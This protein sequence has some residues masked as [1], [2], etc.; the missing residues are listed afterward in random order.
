MM[1][2]MG[3]ATSVLDTV[4]GKAAEFPRSHASRVGVRVG[5][6]SGV[7]VETLRFCI[8]SLAARSEM[9]GLRVEIDTVQNRNQCEQC[10]WEFRVVFYSDQAD[11]HCPYCNSEQTKPLSGGTE[12]DVSFIELEE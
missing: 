9:E 4:R 8:E 6:W 2:E 1:H 7:D 3:V 11:M 5:E 10:G 12:L